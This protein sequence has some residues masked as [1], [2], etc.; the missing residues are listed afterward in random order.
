[1]PGSRC[2]TC[3]RP[4]H[5]LIREP[6]CGTTGPGAAST[7][8]LPTS[9][10]RMSRAR[11]GNG[12]KLEQVLSGGRRPLGCQTEPRCRRSDRCSSVTHRDPSANANRRSGTAHDLADMNRTRR[13][14]VNLQ[15]KSALI[16][17]TLDHAQ[18]APKSP[19]C[20]VLCP[21]RTR[22]IGHL[23]VNH[24]PMICAMRYP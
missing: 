3:K 21:F 1:M 12:H 2:A 24:S 17:D 15:H 10:P 7:G 5:M 4:R 23:L 19:R 16:V 13:R 14:I 6:G 8:M 20:A 18:W 9:S 22:L 11:P